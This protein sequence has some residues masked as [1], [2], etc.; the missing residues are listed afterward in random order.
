MDLSVL[1]PARNEMFLKDTI[2]NILENIQGDT[3]IIAVLDGAWADPPIPDHPKVHLIY[4]SQSIGQRAATNEA[5]RLSKAKYVMKA[6]AHC[7]FDKGFDVKLMAQCEHDWTVVPRMYNLHVFD[8]QC[9][10]CLNRTYQG[11]YPV[12]CENP[13]CDNT[14]DFERLMVFAPRWNRETDFARF[15]NTLHFQYWGG[16]KKR[17]EA[18]GKD[19][20]ADL[21]CFVGATFFMERSRYWEIGGLDEKHGS[22]GQ[23][24]VEISCKSWLS[25][26][27]QVVNKNTW[28]AHLFRTQPGFGFPYPNP[29][30]E[31]ARA[32]SRK[33]WMENT[34]S[35]ARYPLAWLLKKFAPV[36]DWDVIP[37]VPMQ[38]GVLYK[39]EERERE[40]EREKVE[41][42]GKEKEE[43]E[44]KSIDNCKEVTSA[45]EPP[46]P[47]R[48]EKPRPASL[49]KKEEL[50][51]GI[52]YYT[53][54]KCEERIALAVRDRLR[55]CAD[56][57]KLDIVAVSLLP[58]SDSFGR[59]IVMENAERSVLT[60]F[61][62]ILKGIEESTADIIYLTEHDVLYSE[63]HFKF[64]PPRNDTYYYNEHTYKVDSNT[65]QALFYYTKQTSGL[66]GY[67]DLLL[68]HY[69]ARVKRVEEKGFSR[70]MG[71]E[72]GCHSYPRG[73]DNY[74]AERWMAP[75]PNVDIRHGHNLTPSR[76][77]KDLFRNKDACVGWTMVDAIPGWGVVK[78]RFWEFLAETKNR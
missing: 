50:T 13:K 21:M 63:S 5:A 70:H 48:P 40:R 68:D 7:A 64:I 67:R 12:K 51:K 39:E 60:M 55:K 61:K 37:D 49:K 29:G 43:K 76:W 69:R 18:K 16:Y 71:F 6:D 74:P 36:P 77:S 52:V 10:K 66:C 33:L 15:D 46:P 24:G 11:P 56:R 65:G 23:M 75:I 22:W 53:E 45:S 47:Y 78:G 3:E 31:K 20:I 73:V 72:P 27:R 57:E 44:E 54:N 32:H 25:G 4:H 1:I 14:K 17:E 9:K 59:N 58:I 2:D 34:W 28:F 62:Q 30:I 38:N 19:G 8:W 35:G 26:G 41:E 42:T